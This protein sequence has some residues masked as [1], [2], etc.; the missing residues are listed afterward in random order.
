MCL[1][2]NCYALYFAFQAAIK[3]IY[4]L[5]RIF[6]TVIFY[7]VFQDCIK[8]MFIVHLWFLLHCSCCPFW[9][10]MYML[11]TFFPHL[12]FLN[13]LALFNFFVFLIDCF[14]FGFTIIGKFLFALGNSLFF[15]V[16]INCFCTLS[17]VF[18]YKYI[19][20]FTYAHFFFYWF[21]ILFIAVFKSVKIS[22]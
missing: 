22:N 2:S 21:T 7:N 17:T 18:V 4:M 19:Y 13:Y 3:Y 5:M 15:T 11:I 16:C 6:K 8:Y 20:S 9:L 1:S 14:S 10:N 12:L